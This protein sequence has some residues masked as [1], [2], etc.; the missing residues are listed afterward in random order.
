MWRFLEHTTHKDSDPDLDSHPPRQ[1]SYVIT[2]T[3]RRRNIATNKKPQHG[4]GRGRTRRGDD[5]G[6][7]TIFNRKKKKKNEDS[8][9][10]I[11][12]IYTCFV[13]PQSA[14]FL[15]GYILFHIIY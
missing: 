5:G 1:K 2:C 14:G 11:T 13:V 10:M 12:F 9:N 8:A 4:N 6:L 15:I 7:G 3:T